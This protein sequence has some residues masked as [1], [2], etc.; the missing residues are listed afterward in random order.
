MGTPREHWALRADPT[1]D[2]NDPHR[3]YWRLFAMV[4]VVVYPFGYPLFIAR[5]LYN[6][7]ERLNPPGEPVFVKTCKTCVYAI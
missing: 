2:C 7:R 1:V 6:N 3:I 5:L 4:A